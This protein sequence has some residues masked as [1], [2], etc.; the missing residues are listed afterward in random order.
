MRKALCNILFWAMIAPATAAVAQTTDTTGKGHEIDLAFMY[1]P[2][3]SQGTNGNSFWGQGGSVEFAAYLY[4]GWGVAADLSV[5][6]ATNINGSGVK[7]TTITTLFGPHYKWSHGKLAIF[8]N[9]LVGVS[10]G[11]DSV[12]PST[13]GATQS[14]QSYAVQVGGGADW[15]LKQWLAVRPIEA[16]WQRTEF[17]NGTTNV[18]NTLQIGAGV[19]FRLFR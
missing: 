18:Q 16:S 9:G 4:R 19:V 11:S 1:S 15:R 13:G 8:G 7:L 2:Q 10:A 5:N 6:H 3:R 14:A 12:F 17:P